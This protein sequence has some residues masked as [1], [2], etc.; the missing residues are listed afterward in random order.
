MPHEFTEYEYEPEAQAA[1]SRGGGPPRH[2]TGVGVLD[3]LGPPARPSGAKHSL[4][5]RILAAAVLLAVVV[6]LLLLWSRWPG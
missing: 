3:P 2:L 1:S 6:G 5:L 4:L